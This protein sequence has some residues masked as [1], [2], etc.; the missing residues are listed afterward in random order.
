MR[1]YARVFAPTSLSRLVQYNNLAY[2]FNSYVRQKMKL[3]QFYTR[4]HLPL[5]V[6]NSLFL[7]LSVPVP[8]PDAD[9]GPNPDLTL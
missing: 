5:S 9:P 2:W 4:E 6:S 3:R 8:Y 1:Q 7:H